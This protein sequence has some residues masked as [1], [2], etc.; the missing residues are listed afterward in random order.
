MTEDRGRVKVKHEIIGRDYPEI[1]FDE[2]E[3]ISAAIRDKMS[4]TLKAIKGRQK[5]AVKWLQNE[6]KAQGMTSFTYTNKR[7][8]ATAAV[9]GPLAVAVPPLAPLALTLGGA[10]AAK[11]AAEN[12]KSPDFEIRRGLVRSFVEVTYR[13]QE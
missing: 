9:T 12:V 1:S 3:A 6:I 5:V 8:M 11:Y 10:A 4:F 2:K 13:K 7:W